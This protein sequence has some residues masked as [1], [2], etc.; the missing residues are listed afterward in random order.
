MGVCAALVA[1]GGVLGLV[2]IRNPRREVRCED[3]AEGA[4]SIGE[5]APALPLVPARVR[6]VP[7]PGVADH[8]LERPRGRPAELRAR[9]IRGCDQAR[10]IARPAR[11]LADRD[12][13]PVT[14]RAVSITSRT[15]N[16]V[17]APRL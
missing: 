13:A 4:L 12:L 7:G 11:L 5:P 17:P 2:G 15:E 14:A 1:L 3:C 10:R 8:V 16:P 9:E 6:L